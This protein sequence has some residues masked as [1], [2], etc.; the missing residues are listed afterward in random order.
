V[1]AGATGRPG[2][3]PHSR[4]DGMISRTARLGLARRWVPFVAFAA[5]LLVVPHVI[6]EPTRVRQFAEYLCY[7]MVAV[8]LDIA[9]GYGGMLALGQGVFFGLGAYA[10]GMHLSL[11]QVH[12]GELPKFMTL[13]ADYHR[14]PLLWRPFGSL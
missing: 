13:Y 12:H 9:W 2:V 11:E 8:G 6:G 3:V 5:L 10:M 4:A 7:A 14:L 1:P